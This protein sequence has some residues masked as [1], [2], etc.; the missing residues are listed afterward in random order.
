MTF[1]TIYLYSIV[2]CESFLWIL[3]DDFQIV[4]RIAEISSFSFGR[5]KCRHT[6]FCFCIAP[7]QKKLYNKYYAI[8]ILSEKLCS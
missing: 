6:Y 2:K 7:V 3:L 8:H 5:E 1:H 4:G